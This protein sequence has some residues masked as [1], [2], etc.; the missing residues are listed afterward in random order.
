[1]WSAET[2]APEHISSSMTPVISECFAKVVASC[3][4][5]GLNNLGS[6]LSDHLTTNCP[7]QTSTMTAKQSRRTSW[8][9]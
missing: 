7:M 9:P 2:C 6:R 3:S 1:M 4:N 8:H 5:L